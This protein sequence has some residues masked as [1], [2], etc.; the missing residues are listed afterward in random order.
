MNN[1]SDDEPG[2]NPAE[3]Y[4][5]V[6]RMLERL[7]RDYMDILQVQLQRCGIDDLLPV[8]VFMLLDIDEDGV[9]LQ[10]LIAR[11]RYQRS[12]AFNHIRKLAEQ[13]Y[14]EQSRSSHDRRT[15]RLRLTPKATDLRVRLR[16]HLQILDAHFHPTEADRSAA[17]DILQALGRL[18]RLWGGY[19]RYGM[20]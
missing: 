4:L 3:L 8:H 9:S 10:Q 11:G 19:L 12:N 13:G 18:E 14:I 6:P 20:R 17:Q 15:I 5:E 2:Q 1:I 16:S 7:H